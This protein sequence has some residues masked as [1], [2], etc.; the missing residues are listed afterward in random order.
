MGDRAR[1][2][3]VE[4]HKTMA[5][6]AH[7]HVSMHYAERLK[8]MS[9]QDD[10]A[11]KVLDRILGLPEHVMVCLSS[12]M[13]HIAD[14]GLLNVFDLTKYFQ[15]FSARSHM[16]LNGNTLNSL[17]IYQNQ[18]DSTVKGSLFWT[19]DRN[20]TRFGSRLLRN[21]VGR[22][23]LHKT[24][25]EARLEAVEELCD[26][27]KAISVEKLRTVLVKMRSDLEKSLLK[28]YYG[29]CSRTDLLAVL[30]AFQYLVQQYSHA[31]SKATTGFE[32]DLVSKAIMSLPTIQGEITAYLDKINLQA[33]KSDDKYAFFREEH[34]TEDISEH[35]FG[36][37]S[38][39]N[40]LDA[41]K[42]VAAEKLGKKVPVTYNTVAGIDFLIEVDNNSATI[43][44]VPASWA[45][46]SGT[47]AKSRFHPPEVI[48]LVRERDQ[49]K[50]SLAAAC[51][52]AYQDL[53]A[54]IA[55]KY[56][57]FRDAIQSLATLDCLLSLATIAR[58][59]GYVRPTFVETSGI[60]IKGARHPMIEQ[61]LLDSYVPNDVHL[62][63]DATRALLVTGP[64]MGGKSSYVRSIA[65]I[66]IMAQIGSFVPAD[67]ATLGITDAVFTRMGAFDNML[68]GESTFMVE[69]SETSDILKL[70]TERSLV[71]LDELGRG[72]STHDGVAIAGAVLDWLV[73]EKGCFT[74]FITHYQVLARMAEMYENKILRNVH[75]KFSEDEEG[76]DNVTFLYEVGDGVAHWSYGLNVARLAG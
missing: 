47:K 1:V 25:I 19:L 30:Q 36:I 74:L 21:W 63:H 60:D 65:L 23:H 11:S 42:T 58:Q 3:R 6:E 73:R 51:D 75:M 45:K 9:S 7:N 38:V 55:T 40:D 33:A 61:L 8:E 18:T 10:K 14:Y 67:S 24:S 28:I 20:I 50:E 72:T 16:L 41:F 49:H 35:K 64:N 62:S 29:K 70:A 59:P 46:I 31:T 4:K 2:E 12:L 27:D 53:L 34:E 15:P 71:V 26:T 76:G 69:L 48:K 32:S 5:A 56:A 66:T 39:E 44:R 37:A 43:Q 52:A 17:E 68:A 22:P 54:D 13:K 57:S